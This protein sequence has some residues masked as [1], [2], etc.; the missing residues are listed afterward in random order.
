V[1]V[2]M[3]RLV[4][5]PLF[6]HSKSQSCDVVGGSSVVAVDV[7]S[8]IIVVG[9][10]DALVDGSADDAA[11]VISNVVADVTTDDAVVVTGTVV[12][13]VGFVEHFGAHLLFLQ[14]PLIQSQ[15][16]LQIFVLAHFLHLGPPQSVSVSR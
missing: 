15:S 10:S 13:L 2:Q 6:L 3:L 11:D 9:S 7:S 14:K 12:C 1:H 8:G 5:V 4:H 16:T